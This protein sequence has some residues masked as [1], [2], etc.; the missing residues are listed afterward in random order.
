MLALQPS[1]SKNLVQSWILQGKVL[2]NDKVIKKAGYAVPAGA[3]RR[4]PLLRRMMHAIHGHAAECTGCFAVML[5]RIAPALRHAIMFHNT[6]HSKIR[7]YTRCLQA[8]KH[9]PHDMAWHAAQV[10]K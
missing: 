10:N 9:A 3:H 6:I 7:G 8:C 4:A 1:R 2:V 5:I